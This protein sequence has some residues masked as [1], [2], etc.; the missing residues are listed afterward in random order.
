MCTVLL[1]VDCSARVLGSL[2]GAPECG[3]Y[4]LELRCTRYNY[5]STRSI[6][7]YYFTNFILWC[8][9]DTA[10]HSVEAGTFASPMSDVDRPPNPEHL[11]QLR[12][13]V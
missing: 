5:L 1:S 9:A 12:S 10:L 13:K 11:R 4:Q 6:L 8:V 2:G 3:Y 7:Y